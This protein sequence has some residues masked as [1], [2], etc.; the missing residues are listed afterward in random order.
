MAFIMYTN[1]S[2]RESR[3]RVAISSAGLISFTSGAVRELG[4][5]NYQFVILYYNQHEMKIGVKLSNDPNNKASVPLRNKST[6][7]EISGRKF[8][9]YFN[10]LPS[11]SISGEIELEEQEGYLVLN[12]KKFVV[13]AKISQKDKK[14]RKKNG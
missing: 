10:I 5:K 6:R 7:A 11:E 13:K 1:D 9:K 8:F 12:L 2:K 14:G 3:S 4:L